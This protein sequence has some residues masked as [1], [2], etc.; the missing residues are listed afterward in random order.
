MYK[1]QEFVGT[2]VLDQRYKVTHE[3]KAASGTLP[4][5]IARRTPANYLGADNKG[6]KDGTEVKPSDF[7]QADFTAADGKVWSFLGWDKGTA[8]IKAADVHFIGYWGVEP[9]KDPTFSEW[10]DSQVTCE[11]EKV[12]Q[13]RTKTSY[14]YKWNKQRHQWDESTSKKK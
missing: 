8:K 13:T 14:S 9:T 1:R 5:E 11:Q 4:T 2:W 3:F 7:Y 6:I 10:K 12:T